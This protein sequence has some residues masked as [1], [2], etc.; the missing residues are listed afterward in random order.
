MRLS[1]LF[2]DFCSYLSVERGCSPRT[3]VTYRKYFGYFLVFAKTEV[4]GNA[5]LREHFTPELCRRYQYSM[6]QRGLEAASIRVRLAVLASFGKWSARRGR[7]SVNPLDMVT[8][9]RRKSRLPVVP[10][11]TAVE[12]ILGRCRKLRDKAIVA[13]L[14]YGG[15]RRSEVVSLD[16]GD[17][18]SD[19][20]LRRVKGKGEQEAAVA[21]PE[22]ARRIVDEYLEAGR[23]VRRALVPGAVQ[24]VAGA[25]AS[26]AHGPTPGLEAH[27]GHGT[28]FRG[29]RASSACL[30]A[31]VWRRAPGALRRQPQGRAGAPPAPGHR[32]DRDV[33][34]DRAARHA[35]GRGRVRRGSAR[36]EWNPARP[37]GDG[38]TGR[39]S[40]QN[41]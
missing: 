6:A 27:Q 23:Q 1:S 41:G 36:K 24:E 35:E 13:L 34:A 30:P 16:V 26:A 19:F 5:V 7:L 17:Y 22:V 31:C 2:E 32:H 33:H 25:V 39:L 28:A 3:V 11:W 29:P 12:T 40:S 10:R 4:P 18:D 37:P 8:R 21:L 15:L 38:Y 9:P 14:G 20:G